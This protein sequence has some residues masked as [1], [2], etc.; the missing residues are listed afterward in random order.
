MALARVFDKS[1]PN[2][3]PDDG[4]KATAGGCIFSGHSGT[5]AGT[6]R[7]QVLWWFCHV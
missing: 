5:N 4:K 6:L 3:A 2:G 7:E 1:L